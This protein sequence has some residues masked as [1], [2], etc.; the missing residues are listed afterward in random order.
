MK[1]I[2]LVL[3]GE[4]ILPWQSKSRAV[5]QNWQANSGKMYLLLSGEPSP[6]NANLSCIYA[7]DGKSP[8]CKTP[9]SESSISSAQL[10]DL[11]GQIN[12][13]LQSGGYKS[14]SAPLQIKNWGIWYIDPFIT[15]PSS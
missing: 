2:K 13:K 3:I 1:L 4:A 6:I 11:Y 9:D 10:S 14:Q 12:S 7:V 8:T 5:N 15:D